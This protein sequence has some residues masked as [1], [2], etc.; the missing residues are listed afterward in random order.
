MA[1][2]QG[3]KNLPFLAL[4]IGFLLFIPFTYYF[5]AREVQSDEQSP[6]NPQLPEPLIY[7]Q[8]V[9]SNSRVAV[10]I[11]YV[12]STLPPW[13]RTFLF[14]AQFSSEYFDWFIFVTSVKNISTPSNVFLIYVDE[15]EMADKIVRMDPSRDPSEYAFWSNKFLDLLHL[16]PYMLVEFKPALGWIFEVL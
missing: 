12:G 11:P 13:F 6:Q 15:K 3:I 7:P 16:F 14:T 10:I 2:S 1:R 9:Y 4:V 8:S 5:I